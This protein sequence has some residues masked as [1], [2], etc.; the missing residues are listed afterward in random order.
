VRLIGVTG[1]QLGTVP[2]FRALEMARDEGLDLVEVAP[3][4]NPPVCR[5]LDYGKFKY[6]Q[7]K[8]EREAKKH[9]KNV[10][11]REIRM[12]P[13]IA[14]H[15]IDF[16]TR[17]AEKLLREGDKVKVT[18]RFRG[19]QITHPQLGKDLLDQLYDRLK[20]IASIEKPA[21]MEGRAM[22]MILTPG[23][24]KPE[25]QDR[26]PRPPA[27]QAPRQPQPPSDGQEAVAPPQQE[28]VASAAAPA[29][30]PQE[31]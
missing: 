3:T 21:G 12:E 29:A 13:A 23:A 16:K 30:P 26:A 1:E 18:V 10:M 9:Q 28:P 20:T 31:S 22:T 2:L 6:E 27:A 24:A 14:E 19:R 15:D 17:T 4:A 7:A 5:M 25:R 8:K 11:L